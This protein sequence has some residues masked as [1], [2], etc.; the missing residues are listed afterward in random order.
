MTGQ[1]EQGAGAKRYRHAVSLGWFC[2]TA[3]ELDRIGCREASGPFDWL[4]TCSLEGLA[5]ILREREAYF[6]EE[7]RPY[8]ENPAYF[9][10][11]AKKIS[12]FHD[13]TADRPLAEQTAAVREKYARRYERFYR[14]ICEPTLFVRYIYDKK[15]LQYLQEHAGEVLAVLRQFCGGNDLVC[16]VNGDLLEE[17]RPAQLG[18]EEAAIPLYPVAKDERDI[19]ARQFLRKRPDLQRLLLRS[20][21]IPRPRRWLNRLHSLRRRVKKRLRKWADSRRKSRDGAAV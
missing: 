17:P 20:V 13:F 2:G 3:E 12:Y 16:L 18:G 11:P 5:G 6:P 14:T 21:A 7:L 19:V 10:D 1:R 4:L 15:E 8:K 9:Y